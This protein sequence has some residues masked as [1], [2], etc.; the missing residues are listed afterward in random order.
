MVATNGSGLEVSFRKIA[1]ALATLL[2]VSALAGLVIA[3]NKSPTPDIP[4]EDLAKAR[5]RHERAV[6]ARSTPPP[7]SPTSPPKPRSL[8]PR[9]PRDKAKDRPRPTRPSQPDRSGGD[10]DSSS[11]NRP[12]TAETP[13]SKALALKE[14]MDA[15]NRQYDLGDY[16]AAVDAAREIL[17][18]EPRNVRMLR[19][20][21][22]AGCLMGNE[23]Q[24]RLYYEPLPERDKR[25][26]RIRCARYEINL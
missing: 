25:Q 8:R 13:A 2:V 5:Q 6:A 22:S 20:M 14:R 11:Q 1:L 10:E 18:D 21:V 17:Q 19:I 9:P 12:L 15:A 23:D 7:R 24:A 4:E 26:M 16:E 3:V